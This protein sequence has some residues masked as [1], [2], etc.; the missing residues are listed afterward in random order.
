MNAGCAYAHEGQSVDVAFV[1]RL[2]VAM[3]GMRRGHKAMLFAFERAYGEDG[4]VD[5]EHTTFHVPDGYVRDARAGASS[6]LR[7]GLLHPSVPARLRRGARA[8]A[9][10]TA[11]AR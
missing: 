4:A 10:A 6:L 9:A 7:M 2:L 1:R 3:D 8:G 5:L 11:R